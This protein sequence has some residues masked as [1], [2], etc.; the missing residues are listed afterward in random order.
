LLRKCNCNARWSRSLGRAHHGR[1]N[2]GKAARHF[3][4]WRQPQRQERDSQ[5]QAGVAT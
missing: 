4:H 1:F 5:L 3:A 2:R